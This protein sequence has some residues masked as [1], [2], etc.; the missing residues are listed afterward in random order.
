MR[1]SAT[2]QYMPNVGNM[3]FEIRENHYHDGDHELIDFD[4]YIQSHDPKICGEMRGYVDD[5]NF[6]VEFIHFIDGFEWSHALTAAIVD[7]LERSYDLYCTTCPKAK[8]RMAVTI[9]R[10][11]AGKI[12]PGYFTEDRDGPELR[13]ISV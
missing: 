4:F 9:L 8:T 7:Y 3:S 2:H 6:R 12:E 11:L 5:D 1:N 10:H 13:T